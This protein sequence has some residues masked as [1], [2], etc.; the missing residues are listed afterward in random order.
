MDYSQKEAARLYRINLTK[1][2]ICSFISHSVKLY[3]AL[4]AARTTT[5]WT[6]TT[7]KG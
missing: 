2:W 1:A 7:S 5:N 3:D 6:G 4:R